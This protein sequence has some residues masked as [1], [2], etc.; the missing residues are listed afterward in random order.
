MG[1]SAR[2][3]MA[4]VSAVL[5]A[6]GPS[7]LP[8]RAPGPVHLP[9]PGHASYHPAKRSAAWIYDREDGGQSVDNQA[10][11]DTSDSLGKHAGAV[12]LHSLTAALFKVAATNS[13][14]L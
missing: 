12:Q 11:S 10:R 5:A 8:R 6:C 4:R 2:R 1:L 3:L 13:P 14:P 7:G 9:A